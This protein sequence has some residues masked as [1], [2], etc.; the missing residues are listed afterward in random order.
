M[1][2]HHNEASLHLLKSRMIIV[3]HSS[4]TRRDCAKW[5]ILKR[6]SDKESIEA[7]EKPGD[8]MKASCQAHVAAATGTGAGESVFTLG[9]LCISTS[10]APLLMSSLDLLS[11]L[12]LVALT[13][14]DMAM[15]FSLLLPLPSAEAVPDSCGGDGRAVSTPGCGRDGAVHRGTDHTTP[16]KLLRV[17]PPLLHLRH[18]LPERS[19]ARKPALIAP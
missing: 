19:R 16:V 11:L 14:R 6:N 12:P 5:I 18:G 13:P 1:S 4:E 7:K 8:V 15:P 9:A 17:K 3:T 10:T 2:S